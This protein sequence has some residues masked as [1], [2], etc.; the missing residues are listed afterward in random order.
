MDAPL[1]AVANHMDAVDAG[2]RR[3]AVKAGREPFDGIALLDPATEYLAGEGL[4]AAGPRMLRISPVQQQD[5]QGQSGRRSALAEAA[6][7][8]VVGARRS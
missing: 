7:S 2:L 6:G 8:T 1:A 3:R 5:A 4:G